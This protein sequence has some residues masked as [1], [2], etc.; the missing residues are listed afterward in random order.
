VERWL[1]D[2][3][4][5]AY[6]E[7][8]AARAGRWV[9]RHRTTVASAAALLMSAV[10]FLSVLAA[11]EV[12]ARRRSEQEQADTRQQ[13]QRAE[14]LRL[15][16]R[17]N[18]GQAM[19]AVDEM[20]TRLGDERLTNV[21]DFDEERR[22]VLQQALA[23]YGELLKDNSTDPDVR[24]ETGRSHVRMGDIH[25]LLGDDAAAMRDY[26]RAIELLTSLNADH[27]GVP[28][29]EKALAHAHDQK[30]LHS[31]DDETDRRR[32][33]SA[34]ACFRRGLP[35][36]ERL[37]TSDIEARSKVAI[38]HYRIACILVRSGRPADGEKM[39]ARTVE[40]QKEL[41]KTASSPGDVALL[42]SIYNSAGSHYLDSKQWEK[43]EQMCRA[44]LAIFEKLAPAHRKKLKYQYELGYAWHTIG[45]AC[46]ARDRPKEGE[47]GYRKGMAALEE[48]TRI[49]PNLPRYQEEIAGSLDDWANM[50]EG[51]GR[52]AE[53]EKSLCD[54]LAVR[55]KIA[56]RFT[57]SVVF[58]RRVALT[59]VALG[60]VQ[61][62]AGT[63]ESARKS[64]REALGVFAKLARKPGNDGVT[65][66][67][68]MGRT[69]V[70][71][72]ESLEKAGKNEEAR[73]EFASAL[74]LVE[75]IPRKEW[76]VHE[77][78]G[79]AASARA[80]LKRV[81]PAGK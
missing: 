35:I 56:V 77:V 11:F 18:L 29:Y 76:E 33:F 26:D 78:E 27:P 73:A 49:H 22:E 80:G 44:A 14:T 57:K 60:K 46:A 71:L 65:D 3:P 43:T 17:G 61:M 31:W 70:L 81:G 64:F 38:D 63:G 16:A 4:V 55:Q 2:E 54:A 52:L 40:L 34:E 72:G 28:A 62:R 10:V 23:L 9:K 32:L 25:K 12:R 79:V 69:H 15:L 47:E 39:F 59:Y 48:L 42:G 24:M 1:A 74:R 8:L 51:K 13:Y 53:A 21:P 58:E 67:V 20:L 66:R 7:P 37:A 50:Y 68:E 19:R 5:S 6:P 30:G 75:A 45:I 41:L 36:W